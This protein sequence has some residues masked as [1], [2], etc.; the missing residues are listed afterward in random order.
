MLEYKIFDLNKDVNA[1]YFPETIGV[2]YFLKKDTR[3]V[4]EIL[5]G[6][7]EE[8]NTEL[9]AILMEELL[10]SKRSKENVE[11][12]R[13]RPIRTLYI[14]TS[15]DCNLN[16]SYC[17]TNHS[18][19][20]GRESTCI[21]NETIDSVVEYFIKN[22]D[23]NEDREVVYY[24]GEPTIYPEM[25]KYIYNKVREFEEKNG[26]KKCRF[27]LCTN[28][29]NLTDDIV[30]FIKTA[31]IY[32]AVSIDGNREIHDEYRKTIDG[33]GSFDHVKAGYKKLVDKGVCPGVSMTLGTHIA[34]KLPELVKSIKEEFN[35][36]T[37]ATNTMVDYDDEN[38]HNP[39][40][41][42]KK[43]L[44]EI[45]WKSFLVGREEGVYLVKNVMDN[46]VK[47]FVERQK[48][49]WGCTGMGARIGVLP[50]GKL[51]PCMALT[52][53]IAI[54]VEEQPDI[55]QLFPAELKFA[56][57]FL[58][59]ECM[60]CAARS[61]C[62]GGCPAKAILKGNKKD[63]RDADYC[64]ASQ[65]FLENLIK[66]LWELCAEKA[67]PIILEKGLYVPTQE[68]RYLLYGNIEVDN[69]NID[70]QY[71]PKN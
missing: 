36:K 24:G 28:G 63:F 2:V 32:P 41:P 48:R 27:I 68:D 4:E 45:L 26:A 18:I 13:N 5:S 67:K 15:Y 11:K 16:C 69:M 6:C 22:S 43:E 39:L 37:L 17:L 7:N 53:K 31:G 55:S 42:G 50:D 30:E 57:P 71:A 33:T 70:F 10:K 54:P 44:S 66:L 35:P 58:R 49:F 19:S 8:N 64:Y 20:T 46:R 51:T 29:V 61:T 34:N 3:L 40:V 60:M 59:N 21:S 38:N 62:G 9:C 25:M 47:P 1:V 52:K 14:C 12:L 65:Y 23:L 56:S